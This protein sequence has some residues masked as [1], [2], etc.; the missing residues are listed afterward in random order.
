[1]CSVDHLVI[2]IKSVQKNS[3]YTIWL[4]NLY[5]KDFALGLLDG[6]L[7]LTGF[8]VEL[9][10][11]QSLRVILPELQKASSTFSL[12]ISAFFVMH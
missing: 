7:R 10:K 2:Y 6:V 8:T 11:I 12:S 4:F 9:L 5:S 1:M 3:L